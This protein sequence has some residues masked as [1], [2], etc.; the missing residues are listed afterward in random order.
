MKQRLND[1]PIG[2][3]NAISRAALAAKWGCSDRM[4][5]RYI[6]E[7][8]CVE[9]ER[10]VIVSHSNGGVC[11]YYRTDDP[12]DIE[13][14]LLEM[15]KRARNTFRSLRQARRVMKRLQAEQMH[16]EGFVWP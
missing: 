13:Y 16:G 4:A 15:T 7:L 2:R 1:I 8:R 6:A 9:D 3:E 14:F 12:N 10:Y 5:R 11:G